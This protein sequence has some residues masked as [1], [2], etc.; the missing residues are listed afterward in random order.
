MTNDEFGHLAVS[1]DTVA[2]CEVAGLEA[3]HC[4][5]V[6]IGGGGEA[7]E[8][9]GHQA[10]AGGGDGGQNHGDQGSQHAAVVGE[11]V[12]VLDVNYQ[13]RSRHVLPPSRPLA[14]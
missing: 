6:K 5:L 13:W 8:A 10:Q 7:V 3:G 2:P 9:M 11:W 4:L 12:S 1:E 14:N